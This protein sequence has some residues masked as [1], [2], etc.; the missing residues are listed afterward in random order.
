MQIGGIV[1]MLVI[2]AGFALS[3]RMVGVCWRRDKWISRNAPN[4]TV[5]KLTTKRTLRQEIG[6]CA[7][8]LILLGFTLSAFIEVEPQSPAAAIVFYYLTASGRVAMSLILT[9]CSIGDIWDRKKIHAELNILN[10]HRLKEEV[11][12]REA[13]AKRRAESAKY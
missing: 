1:T 10:A 7:C 11:E 2:L 4:H 8:Q 12:W 3:V 6:Y 5:A 13:S 9:L